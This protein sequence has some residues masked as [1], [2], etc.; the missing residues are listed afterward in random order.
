ME[1]FY[2]YGGWED[3][4]QSF[5][6]IEEAVGYIETLD[7]YYCKAHIV[8][9]EKIILQAIHGGDEIQGFYWDFISPQE[10]YAKRLRM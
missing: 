6:T 4:K 7:C 8:H 9:R 10:W 3:F 2:P 1:R 5:D